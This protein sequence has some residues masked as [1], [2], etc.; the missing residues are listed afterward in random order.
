MN[1]LQ[2][3]YIFNKRDGKDNAGK[4]ST[5]VMSQEEIKKVREFHKS[6]SEYKVTPL[7]ALNNLAKE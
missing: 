7:H 6:F 3:E 4:A 2:I 5:E 1:S